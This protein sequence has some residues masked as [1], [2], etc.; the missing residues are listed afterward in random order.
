MKNYK[1]S[2][3]SLLFFFFLVGAERREIEVR[4]ASGA[5]RRRS[6]FPCPLG[7]GSSGGPGRP[8]SSCRSGVR[9]SRGNSACHGGAHRAARRLLTRLPSRYIRG[10]AETLLGGAGGSAC[11][12]LAEG[13]NEEE[14]IFNESLAPSAGSLDSA[15]GP[16]S[17]SSPTS[18]S[19]S[20]RLAASAASASSTV[21]P[22]SPAA[23]AAA[24]SSSL[25]AM[26]CISASVVSRVRL[27]CSSERTGTS[28]KPSKKS[29]TTSSAG[30][31]QVGTIPCESHSGIIARMRSSAELLHSGT[32]PPAT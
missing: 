32:T 27:F 10:L 6:R 2:K 4:L 28:T 26:R 20:A 17:S 31:C 14:P 12:E 5:M 21:N 18:S 1:C 30:S 11:G 25:V 22:N 29:R 3:R 24:A 7:R 15:S 9:C 8:R 19:R 16:T 23:A 13:G